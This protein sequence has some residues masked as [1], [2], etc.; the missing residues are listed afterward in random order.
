M[1]QTRR[2]PA[3]RYYPT[4]IAQVLG[5]HKALNKE[6]TRVQTDEI[7]ISQGEGKSAANYF[8]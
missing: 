6:D 8:L 5:A 1:T 3:F 4:P 7:R 2:P